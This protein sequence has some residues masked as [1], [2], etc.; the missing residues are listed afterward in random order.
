MEVRSR[1]ESCNMYL[2]W[3]VHERVSQ[4]LKVKRLEQ[5]QGRGWS[6]EEVKNKP[7][8][9]KEEDLEEMIGWRSMSQEEVLDKYEV[10]ESIREAY[11]G[12]GSLLELR[13]YESGEK[14]VGRALFSVQ[15]LHSMHEDSTE[16]ED[17]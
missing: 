5:E 8:T 4:E 11:K 3:F 2:R 10:E 15:R 14:I 12:R 9:F 1:K 17:M 6:T 7:N 13:E 16:G